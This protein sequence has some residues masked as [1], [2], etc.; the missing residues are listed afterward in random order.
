MNINCSPT[1]TLISTRTTK[2]K[3]HELNKIQN[4]NRTYLI[5]LRKLI[6]LQKKELSP[7][8]VKCISDIESLMKGIENDLYAKSWDLTREILLEKHIKNLTRDI[9]LFTSAI[10]KHQ[11]LAKENVSIKIIDIKSHRNLLLKGAALLVLGLGIQQT[12]NQCFHGLVHIEN[13]NFLKELQMCPLNEITDQTANQCVDELVHIDNY[14]F[15]DESQMCPLEGIDPKKCTLVPLTLAQFPEN[16]LKPPHIDTTIPTDHLVEFEYERFFENLNSKEFYSLIECKALDLTI[17]S[18][19]QLKKIIT[20]ISSYNIYALSKFIAPKVS[21][22]QFLSI[23]YD[24]SE[25]ESVQFRENFSQISDSK[26]IHLDYEK[27]SPYYIK[28]LINKKKLPIQN[29]ADEKLLKIIN[30]LKYE[31]YFL[32][33][34]GKQISK[35]MQGRLD[36][37][38]ILEE[39][40]ITKVPNDQLIQMNFEELSKD[41]IS[42]LLHR[43]N[44]DISIFS[45]QQL[46]DIIVKADYLEFI[47]KNISVEQFKNLDV[48]KIGQYKF[49]ELLGDRFRELIP[50]IP[51][52]YIHLLESCRFGD[53]WLLSYLEKNQVEQLDFSKFYDINMIFDHRE[54]NSKSITLKELHI[55]IEQFLSI[56]ETRDPYKIVRSLNFEIFTSIPISML[57][58]LTEDKLKIL[59]NPWEEKEANKHEKDPDNFY[60]DDWDLRCKTRNYKNLNLLS[61][62]QINAIKDRLSKENANLATIILE[63]RK[64][65][66]PTL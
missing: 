19:E 5:S 64:K 56:L 40:D 47:S 4:L 22:A 25:K 53:Y 16:C 38:K 43:E 34:I 27:M 14:N 45:I 8:T 48:K 58:K 65:N 36:F 54:D 18:N 49:K 39:N 46:T 23:I 50:Y 63:T 24:L 3:H 55:S 7:D 28:T 35:Q 21:E 15:L 51:V 44:L 66:L 37:E 31:T 32:Q 59:F 1:S 13:Y 2:I 12:A 20:K 30:K 26:L 42:R 9:E 33:D 62:D 10:L 60:R 11:S 41:V 29:F 17:F 6:L 52:Q 61:D 57:G